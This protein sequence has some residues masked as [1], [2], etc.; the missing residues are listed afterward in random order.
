MIVRAW[1]GRAAASNPTGYPAHFR[2]NVAPELR[3][4]AG[5]L[6]ASLLRTSQ[7]DGIE[8]LV[9]TRWQSMDAIRAFA[10]DE[11]GNAVVE[12]GAVAALVDF[13]KTVTHYEVVQEVGVAG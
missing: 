6:G 8:F 13:D 9:L 10:G 11:V 3:H 5:F 2:Q 12:P 4:I 7:P 1:R